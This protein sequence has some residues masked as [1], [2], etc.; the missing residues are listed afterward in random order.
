MG[1]NFFN[2]VILSLSVF[3]FIFLAMSG[4]S[5]GKIMAQDAFVVS[6]LPGIKQGLQFAFNDLDR[7]PQ[8]LEFQ[9]QKLMQNY[10]KPF[11]FKEFNSNTCPQTYLYKRISLESYEFSFCLENSRQGY[12]A[13]WNKIIGA[14]S[15]NAGL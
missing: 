11:P 5:S 8:V 6:N 10:F 13:G 15:S 3:V 14:P 2:L 4:W 12:K 1:R 7:Y 9:D